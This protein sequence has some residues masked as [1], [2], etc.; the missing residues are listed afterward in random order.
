[1]SD[2]SVEK[3][4]ERN[5][6]TIGKLCGFT[7]FDPLPDDTFEH[8]KNVMTPETL[9]DYSKT[10][11]ERIVDNFYDEENQT[12]DEIHDVMKDKIRR[13]VVIAGLIRHII[14]GAFVIVCSYESFVV[15]M[16]QKDIKML[17][18]EIRKYGCRLK[19]DSK[20]TVAKFSRIKENPWSN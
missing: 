17:L 19:E 18:R 14:K 10:V 3:K 7:V 4:E 16:E 11:Y 20:N 6:L 1:M 2:N 13:S 9:E 15:E 12:W 8:Y 5:P